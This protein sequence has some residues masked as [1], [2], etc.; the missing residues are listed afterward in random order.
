ME[1]GKAGRCG[2]GVGDGRRGWELRREAAL[3]A[4]RLVA[5]MGE[6]ERE[7]RRREEKIET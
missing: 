2:G 1:G 3:P 6:R 7:E 4:R 5:W